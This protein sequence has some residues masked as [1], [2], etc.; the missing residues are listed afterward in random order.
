MIKMVFW[1]LVIMLG[2]IW[3]IIIKIDNIL[4]NLAEI[5]KNKKSDLI[6]EENIIKEKEIGFKER[7]LFFENK[8]KDHYE[9]IEVLYKEK[10]QG[11]PWLARAYS[12]YSLLQDSIIADWL[13]TK[14]HP[15]VRSAEILRIASMEKTRAK[16]EFRI[17]KYLLEMY[18][19]LFPFLIDFR[20][21]DL[22]DYIRVQLGKY[23]KEGELQ[24]EVIAYTTEG[25]RN[26][27]TKQEIFQRALDRYWQKKKN[28]W[29]LGRVYER[30]IGYL[31]EKQGYSVYYQGIIEGL[32]DLG[33]DL[34]AK[35]GNE[36]AVI[37]CKYWSQH[38]TIH[39]KHICQLFG[40]TLKYWIEHQKSLKSVLGRQ[41]E[42]FQD[43]IQ[44]KTIKGI[45][46]TSTALSPTA[47]EF[48]DALGIIVKEN[49]MFNKY[50][51]IKCNS[52]YATGE[53]IYHLPFDQQ[54][55]R[56]T[57]EEERNE[58]YVET[59]AEAE[60]LGYRRA[61]RWRGNKDK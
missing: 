38:R 30:Y 51:S 31:Y 10:S 49:Y 36:I 45:F 56:T 3:I 48:A 4:K 40:T 57:I 60:R 53:K 52:S 12:D 25:E 32:E 24:D 13:E 5:R 2:L 44:Q 27:L 42:L 61:F 59:V 11:F 20:G 14:P 46:I 16:R 19:S 43:I 6:K 23:Y 39:E 17:L 18:E 1:G 15:A 47:R 29:E 26:T 58:K 28:S 8:I 55:D 9:A 7:Q 34:I 50:P 41:K 37:Q 54:Y 22:D 33:R 35:K 21:E